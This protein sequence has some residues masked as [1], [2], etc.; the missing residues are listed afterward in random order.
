[1]ADHVIHEHHDATADNSGS[2]FLVGMILLAVVLFVLFFYGL[3]LLQSAAT[4][5]V[6]VPSQIDVNLN[7]K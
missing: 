7:Q 1:M 5:Q 3:P 6:S 2:G 4:P